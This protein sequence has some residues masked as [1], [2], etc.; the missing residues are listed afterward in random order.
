MCKIIINNL[1]Q[2][3][4]KLKEGVKIEELLTLGFQILDKDYKEDNGIDEYDTLGVSEGYIFDLGHARRGQ[5]YYLFC[6]FSG[7]F[8]I[9]AS[10]PDGSGGM[11]SLA[12]IDI[13]KEL[14]DKGIVE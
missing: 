4:M 3:R 9:Y 11:C 2:N 5:F 7:S 6:H 13:F 10:E 14:Y 12:Y 8:S 1:K